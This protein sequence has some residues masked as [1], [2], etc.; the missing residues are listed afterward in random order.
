MR[1]ALLGF[2]LAVTAAVVAWSGPPTVRPCAKYA[3]SG[4]V[5]TRCASRRGARVPIG[6]PFPQDEA[7]PYVSFEIGAGW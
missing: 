6:W 4:C 3:Q 5:P 2:V 1:T 7:Q